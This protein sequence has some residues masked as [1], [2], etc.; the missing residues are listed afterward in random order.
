LLSGVGRYIEGCWDKWYRIYDI[1]VAFSAARLVLSKSSSS[2]TIST[3]MSAFQ[4]GNKKYI[5]WEWALNFFLWACMLEEAWRTS[6]RKELPQ[7]NY[8]AVTSV[9]LGTWRERSGMEVRVRLKM[10]AE[11]HKG[12]LDE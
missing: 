1:L 2:V 8:L 4:I 12:D 11:E 10:T 3:Q 5:F 9:V 7:F 6:G